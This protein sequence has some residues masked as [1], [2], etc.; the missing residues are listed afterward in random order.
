MKDSIENLKEDIT[1]T[2]RKLTTPIAKGYDKNE[3]NS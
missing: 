3:H 1:P 2:Q